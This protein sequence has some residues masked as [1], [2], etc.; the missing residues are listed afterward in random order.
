MGKFLIGIQF[1]FSIV[2][3]ITTGLIYDQMQHFVKVDYGFEKEN[4]I[5]IQLQDNDFESYSNLI[6]FYS[7]VKLVAG[8]SMIPGAGSRAN[9]TY[10][11]KDISLSMYTMSVDHN[12]LEILGLTMV[13]GQFFDYPN[14][15]SKQLVINE[16]GSSEF[17]FEKPAEIIGEIVEIKNGEM[18]EVIGVVKDYYFDLLASQIGPLAI[19]NNPD[20]FR[21]AIVEISEQNTM[22][23][24]SFLGQKWN[25]IDEIHTFQYE[26]F[27][28]QIKESRAFMGD[29]ASTIGFISIV[30]VSIA[31]LGLLGMVTYSTETR[32]KEIGIRKVMGA[33][34]KSLLFLLSKGFISMMIISIIFAVIISYLLNNIWLEQ[35]AHR[36][37]FGFG[38][39][40]I[41][42][43]FIV[44]LGTLTVGLQTLQVALAKPS[45]TLRNE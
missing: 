40:G 28:E 33:G 32:V 26:F 2:L 34:V 38:N 10:I 29:I 37:Q 15:G 19:N 30:A 18:V 8:S 14:Y 44:L 25:E 21:Y 45:E 9:K 3:I 27:D 20:N 17:G 24:L 7:D 12:Y 43:L 39:V 36:I 16:A 4:I 23:T 41:S 35:I 42:L 5:N 22:E 13:A 1:V 11:H 6:K 31:S